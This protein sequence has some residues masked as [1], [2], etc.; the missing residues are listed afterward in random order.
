MTIRVLSLDFD[1]CLAHIAY[2]KS[3]ARDIIDSNRRFLRA[4]RRDNHLYKESTIFIGSNRQSKNT[5]NGNAKNNNAFCF[6]VMDEVK[7]YLQV[8]FDTFLLAD[9]YGDLQ[10]G[11]SYHRAM[12]KGYRGAHAGWIFDET[13]VTLLYAQMHKIAHEEPHEP[14]IFDFYDDR[15]EDILPWLTTFYTDYPELIPNNVTLRLN[16]YAGA[17]HTLLSQI[18]GTGFIDS[19]YRQTVKDMAEQTIAQ[20]PAAS[21]QTKIYAAHDVQPDLLLNRVSY[22]A[23]APQEPSIPDTPMASNLDLFSQVCEQAAYLPTPS[24]ESAASSAPQKRKRATDTQEVLEE[25]KE[26]QLRELSA[27]NTVINNSFARFF[28]ASDSS[29]VP[30]DEAVHNNIHCSPGAANV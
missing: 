6:P 18:Q 19:N 2:L 8:T 29:A 7:D 14:I 1:G 20:Q 12:N 22:T 5:E 28:S 11:L 13:K 16:H 27:A 21:I 4:L 26:H 10:A 9:I 17:K 25:Y 24:Q 15:S 23:P 3:T 30:K